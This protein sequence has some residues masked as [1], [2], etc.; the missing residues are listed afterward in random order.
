MAQLLSKGRS[1][2]DADEPSL[3]SHCCHVDHF[4]FVCGTLDYIRQRFK[5]LVVFFWFNFSLAPAQRNLIPM[6]VLSSWTRNFPMI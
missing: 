5:I 3:A 6:D 2:S 1:N 4:V